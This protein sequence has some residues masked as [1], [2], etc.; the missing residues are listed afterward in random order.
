[1]LE[2]AIDR[3]IL[4][5]GRPN[6]CQTT[7]AALRMLLAQKRFRIRNIKSERVN[8]TV[9]FTFVVYRYGK[10]SQKYIMI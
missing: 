9:Q 3:K 8:Q 5:A 7:L 6:A 2:G 1:M 10:N 4:T